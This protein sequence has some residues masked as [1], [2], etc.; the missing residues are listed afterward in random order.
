MSRAAQSRHR[1]QGEI[2]ATI[3]KAVNL[4]CRECNDATGKWDEVNDCLVWRCWLYPYRPGTGGEE[5]KLRVKSAARSAAAK[6]T[7]ARNRALAASKNRQAPAKGSRGKG[8]MASQRA[9]RCPQTA[10]LRVDTA[11]L[12]TT[13][14]ARR[15][16]D[17]Q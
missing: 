17:E 10:R 2:P 11:P 13:P 15:S 5:R 4:H 16:G 1:E 3:R 6:A 7:F 8:R 14:A 12:P 9:P